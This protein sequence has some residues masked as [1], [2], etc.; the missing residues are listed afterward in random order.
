MNDSINDHTTMDRRSFLKGALA[1]GA[2]ASAA[3]VGAGVL[4]GCAAEPNQTTGDSRTADSGKAFSRYSFETAPEPIAEADINETVDAD[5]VVVGAGFS[6]LCCALSAAENGLNV[7]LVERGSRVI[8]RGGSIYAM[9]SKLTKEK[10]YE[11]S[12]EEIAQRYKRM[13]GYHSYRVDGTKW[14]LHYKRSGEAMD[15]L[16]D[17]MTTASEVGGSDLTPVMEHWYEDPEN[18]NGEFSGTHEFLDGPNG[19]GPDDNPQQDVCDNMA[20]YCEKAGVDIRYET[21]AQQLVKEGDAVVAVVGKTGNGYVRFNGSKGVVIATGDFGQ[22]KEMLEKFI[23]WAAHQ[24]EFGGIWNGTGHKMAYWAGAA[25]DKNETPTPMIFCFQWRSITRQVRAFQGLMVNAEGKRYDNEDNVISHG[26]LALMHEKG[27]HSFAIWDDDYANEPQWQNH[28]Y[29]D[30]P[31]VFDTPDD[32]R[33]YWETVINGPGTINMNGSGDIEV[34]MIKADTIEELVDQLELPKE[35]TLKT[36]ESYNGYCETGVDEEFGKRAELLLPIK[37]GPFYGIKCTPWF[38][39]TTGGIRCNDQMQVLNE[40]NEAIEGLYC[41]GSTVG[42]MYCNCYSTHFPGHNL[43]ATCLTFG[44][45]TGRYLA[46][47]ETA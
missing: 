16:I 8:G 1:T 13:M 30:G 47:K 26:G 29:V 4:T 42:D 14:M 6:G 18:I 9:N 31:K 11:C 5:V 3:V 20:L 21:D 46:G 23:P 19:K 36:I 17:R 34:K 43:G 39:T 38:L 44:Y 10:G 24:T 41:L 37:N 45:L 40:E 12:V 35:Q 33:A 28:R 27:H 7:V 2:A 32:V 22:D 15:W 25:I